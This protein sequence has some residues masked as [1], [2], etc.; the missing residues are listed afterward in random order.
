MKWCC[1]GCAI[2][3]LLAIGL[4]V[5]ILFALFAWLVANPQDDTFLQ[6]WNAHATDMNVLRDLLQADIADRKQFTKAYK[7]FEKLYA[8]E[9]WLK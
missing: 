2:K 5:G 4:S 3:Q 9:G 7:S 1:W 6:K 8:D